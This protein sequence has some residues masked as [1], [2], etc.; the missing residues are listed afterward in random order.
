MSSGS[1]ADVCFSGRL[2]DVCLSG[3]LA[4]VCLSGRSAD[5]C[6]SGT[7]TDVSPRVSSSSNISSSSHYHINHI[8][9]QQ[10]ISVICDRFFKK[11]NHN[12]CKG[13]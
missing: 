6:L 13:R 3:R 4:D 11:I 7:L 12:G 1:P 10:I 9:C 8:I 5:V 2:A